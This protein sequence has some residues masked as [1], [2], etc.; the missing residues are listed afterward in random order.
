GSI[1]AP[2]PCAGRHRKSKLF[3]DAPRLACVKPAASVHPEPGSNSSLSVFQY[4]RK[5]PDNQGL[6][7]SKWLFSLFTLS[8]CNMYMN[9]FF[10]LSKG[11]KNPVLSTA[12]AFQSALPYQLS[13]CKYRKLILTSQIVLG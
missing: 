7:T 10:S 13:G 4:S 8:Y 6:L 3:R 11:G 12:P 5:L 2:H 9:L 1:R